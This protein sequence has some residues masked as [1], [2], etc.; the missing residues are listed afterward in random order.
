MKRAERLEPVKKIV[1]ENE[2]RLAEKVAGAERVLVS[3][4]QK[5]Q[6]L[7]LY[8]G[9]YTNGLISRA[10]AGMGARELVDYQAFLVRL[11]AAINQQSKVVHQLR[12]ERDAQ[13]QLWME[14]A[15]RARSMGHVI[16]G[17]QLEEQ[18]L[19]ARREQRETDER[20]QRRRVARHE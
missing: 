17:W 20:A 1:D 6:E 2:R 18:R 7:V 8:R 3:A 5:L 16:E 12:S 14:A 13:R 19:M 11:D 10:G 4:E 15:Q 9:D